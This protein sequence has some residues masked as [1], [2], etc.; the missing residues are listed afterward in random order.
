[1]N[2]AVDRKNRN[3][4]AAVK[5]LFRQRHAKLIRDLI[6]LHTG[7][8]CLPDKEFDLVGFA[9]TRFA[10]FRRKYVFLL[11]SSLAIFFFNSGDLVIKF[12]GRRR[13]FVFQF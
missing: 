5:K 3:Q 7:F 9:F 11:A 13:F 4:K 2:L 6:Q 1:M 12:G 8:L 10:F